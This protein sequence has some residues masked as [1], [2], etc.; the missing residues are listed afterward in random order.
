MLCASQAQTGGILVIVD[1]GEGLFSG[2]ELS[3][4]MRG[5]GGEYEGWCVF[6]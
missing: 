3:S 5:L 2:M 4:G 1:K 6:V